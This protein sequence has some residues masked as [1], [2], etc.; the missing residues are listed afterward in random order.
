M[1]PGTKMMFLGGKLPK[2]IDDVVVD[3]KQFDATGKKADKA[4]AGATA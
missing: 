3:L 2:Q 1:V 4:S